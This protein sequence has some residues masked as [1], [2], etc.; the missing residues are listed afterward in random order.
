MDALKR[1]VL[2]ATVAVASLF[3]A[4]V[5]SLQL[6][7][8]LPYPSLSRPSTGPSAASG[9]MVMCGIAFTAWGIWT[10]WRCSDSTIRRLMALLSC[11][12]VLWQALTLI[13]WTS[14]DDMVESIGWYLYYVPMLVS[15]V[16]CLL[17]AARAA[18]LDQRSW[19]RPVRRAIVA[20]DVSL[21]VLVLSNNLHHLV[22]DF[23]FLDPLWSRSYS[24]ETCFWVILGWELACYAAFF[25]VLF[26]VARAH[27]RSAL[28][29]ILVIAVLGVAYALLYV[30]R[31]ESL[32][33]SSLPL[34]YSLLVILGVE[35]CFDLGLLPSFGWL[36]EAFR[37]LP[38]DL[39]ILPV[40]KG[41]ATDQ[42][43]DLTR[44]GRGTDPLAIETD[45]ARGVDPLIER[46]L[47]ARDVPVCGQVSFRLDERPNVAYKAFR[48]HGGIALL[49]EDVSRL[50]ERRRTLRT[51]QEVLRER[52]A[53]LV[54]DEELRRGLLRLRRER[55]LFEEVDRTLSSSVEQMR[56][57]MEALPSG[58]SQEARE[59]RRHELMRVKLLVGYCKRRGNLVIARQ[60][61]PRMAREQIELV[62]SEAML[63]LRSVGVECAALI[64]ADGP[65]PVPDVELVYD[66]LYDVVL[67][68]FSY[69]DLVL[70]LHVGRSDS[71]HDSTGGSLA[72]RI[73]AETGDG[74]APGAV[75]DLRLRLARRSPQPD[76]VVTGSGI[77]LSERLGGG[78]V[79]WGR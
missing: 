64:E 16:L 44:E 52:N 56:E 74:P 65:L 78:E 69:P 61:A 6:D 21:I 62:M 45:S 76:L 70:M 20:I 39:Q 22:F 37:K 57:A 15:P 43:V 49:T 24:Y 5:V 35:M 2:L 17:S 10:Y 48:L 12:F 23:S 79:P 58:D 34:T 42:V 60:D 19:A 11:L 68:G 75:A 51:Q 66:I 46:A 41:L 50:D 54:H 13:K 73:V 8:S 38:F 27:A 33:V 3:V 59:T 28:L 71:H 29:P 47:A 53:L 72:L 63:D 4:V 32:L 36:D 14:T 30:L 7:A 9:L 77:V 18:G 67:A 55:T 26:V 1:N 31:V 25:V 40:S